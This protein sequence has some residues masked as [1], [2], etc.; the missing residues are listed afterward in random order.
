MSLQDKLRGMMYSADSVNHQNAAIYLT[1]KKKPKIPLKE[2]DEEKNTDVS[3]VTPYSADKFIEL[4]DSEKQNVVDGIAEKFPMKFDYI[5]R[6]DGTV[7]I[8]LNEKADKVRQIKPD[9]VLRYEPDG[10]IK[11]TPEINTEEDKIARISVQVKY[12]MYG[13]TFNK[14]TINI[15]AP[16]AKMTDV[17]NE[18][19]ETA[20]TL[21]KNL[22]I[23]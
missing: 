11:I 12:N 8:Y 1:S 16:N 23:I 19:V 7:H 9:Y 21:T 2:A 14:R 3:T 10:Q 5:Y 6:K 18:I 13:D 17:V 4:W 15:S 20:Y 22:S